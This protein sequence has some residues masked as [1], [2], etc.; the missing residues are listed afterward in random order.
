MA[1]INRNAKYMQFQNCTK[2]LD[3]LEEMKLDAIFFNIE[4]AYDK[5]NKY[6]I[7]E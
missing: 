7:L 5:I 6:K 2:N 4:K 1:S 3:R